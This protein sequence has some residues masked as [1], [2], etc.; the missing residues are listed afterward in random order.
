MST[1]VWQI[2]ARGRSGAEL[3]RAVGLILDVTCLFHAPTTMTNV[4]KFMQAL[5][6]LF[7]LVHSI[8]EKSFDI[9]GISKMATVKSVEPGN[10]S[11]SI[12][13]VIKCRSG[14]LL[15]GFS[16]CLLVLIL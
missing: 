13:H 10:N 12:N 5:Q 16:K 11:F 7:S 15:L 8:A 6:D 9:W 3:R 4:L 2:K 1:E 14:L